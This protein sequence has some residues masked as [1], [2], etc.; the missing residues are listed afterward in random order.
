MWWRCLV[1]VDFEEAHPCDLRG[2]IQALWQYREEAGAVSISEAELTWRPVL[3]ALMGRATREVIQ[4]RR[5]ERRENE[6]I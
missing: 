3:H 2:T 5:K 1:P 6:K 4:E